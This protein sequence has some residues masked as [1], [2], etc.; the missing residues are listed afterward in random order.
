MD[1]PDRSAVATRV[2][3]CTGLTVSAAAF[4][5]QLSDMQLAMQRAAQAAQAPER[6]R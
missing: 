4:S 3:W 5:R 1:S 6:A 2:E